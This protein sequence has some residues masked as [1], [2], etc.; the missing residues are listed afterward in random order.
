MAKRQR[1]SE[2]HQTDRLRFK[3][4]RLDTVPDLSAFTQLHRL[5]LSKTTGLTD[6]RWLSPVAQTLTWLSLQGSDLKSLDG[7]EKLSKVL[8]TSSRLS[9]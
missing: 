3:G 1:L 2:D 9:R 7:I 8:G 5:D 4:Q 6:L